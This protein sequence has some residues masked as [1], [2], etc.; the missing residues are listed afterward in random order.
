M[1]PDES[2]TGQGHTNPRP[3]CIGDPRAGRDSKPH[4]GPLLKLEAFDLPPA[5]TFGNCGGRNG[6]TEGVKK[7]SAWG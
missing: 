3:N 2:G 1:A 7:S 6:H 5:G 4:I